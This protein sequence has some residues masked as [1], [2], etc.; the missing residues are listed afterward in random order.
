MYGVLISGYTNN[1]EIE[2]TISDKYV[3]RIGDND[4]YLVVDENKNTYKVSDLFFNFKFNSTDIY[5]NLE[6]G[7]T[8]KVKISGFRIRFLSEYPNINEV[9]KEEK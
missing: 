2:I 1:K 8:Y 6:I 5:N 3:K 9:I 7:E 4:V